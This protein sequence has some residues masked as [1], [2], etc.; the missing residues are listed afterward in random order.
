MKLPYNGAS[1]IG[2]ENTMPMDDASLAPEGGNMEEPM[3][4]DDMSMD[5]MPMASDIP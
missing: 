2:E 3:P 4:M 5:N 1:S